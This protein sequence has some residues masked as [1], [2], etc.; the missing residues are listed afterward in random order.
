MDLSSIEGALDIPCLDYS[1]A[2][3]SI[4]GSA[5]QIGTVNPGVIEDAVLKK[6]FI[7]YVEKMKDKPRHT[8]SVRKEIAEFGYL[9]K[10][11]WPF[12][13]EKQNF[14]F[15]KA[16]GIGLE[17]EESGFIAG[18][19]TA[20]ELATGQKLIFGSEPT[21]TPEEQEKP[22]HGAVMESQGHQKQTPTSEPD[23]PVQEEPKPVS[24]VGRKYITTSQIGKLFGNSNWV[25]A[26]RIERKLFPLVDSEMK[27]NFEKCTSKNER[28][29]VTTF[30]KLNRAACE[31][32]MAY[33]EAN[34]SSRLNIMSGIA[35]MKALVEEVFDD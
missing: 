10:N 12:D 3:K 17:F 34:A 11:E 2:R 26:D 15:D 20:M 13:V 16:I 28:G 24:Y 7:G 32:Y 4:G 18:F 33:M 9:C 6:M 19:K 30:Y 21:N 5:K 35:Q 31:R 14:V 29:R 8:Q 23:P 25:I 27:K 22:M 1:T